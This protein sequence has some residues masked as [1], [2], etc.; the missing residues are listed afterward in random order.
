[1]KENPIAG[2]KIPTKDELGT[3]GRAYGKHE[4]KILMKNLL[5]NNQN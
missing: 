3:S 4:I 1:M 2:E 5:G